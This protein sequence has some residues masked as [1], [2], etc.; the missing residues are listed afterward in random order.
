MKKPKGIKYDGGK[1]PLN[2][3]SNYAME[4]VAKVLQYGA[5]K[6]HPW[7]WAEGIHYSRVISAARRHIAEWENRK[8]YD[9]GEDCNG[10]KKKQLC[11][12]HS[13]RH[14]LANAICN[15]MFL[16]DYELR[17]LNHLDDRRPEHTLKNTKRKK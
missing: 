3:L 10:C 9:I 7:N 13:K 11:K 4:E 2:L 16:L 1:A 5:T 15:L 14:H 12:T 6:Y 8:T 17:E